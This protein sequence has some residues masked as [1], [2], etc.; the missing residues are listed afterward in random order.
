[1]PKRSVV[2]FVNGRQV[3]VSATAGTTL[4]RFLRDEL[5]LTGTK[6]GC[7]QGQCGACTVLVDGRPEKSCLLKLSEVAGCQVETIE[8]LAG[9]GVLHPLQQAFIQCGAV[10]CGFCTPGMILAA[11]GLL[12]EK[13]D[14]SEEEIKEALSQNLC[15]C[16]GYISVLEAVRHAARVLKEGESVFTPRLPG[17]GR[18]ILGAS[19]PDKDGQNRVTGKLKFAGDIFLDR[20]L[21]GKLLLSPF[22]HAEIISI[23]TAEAKAMPGVKAVLTAEDVPGPNL[24]GLIQP[25]QPV[26]A[27]EKVRFVGDVVAAVFA[28]T[29][30]QAEKAVRAVQLR[31]Q[32]LEV[33]SSPE[34]ALKPD[35]PLIHSGGNLLK[36]ANI[37][38]GD[39]VA[40]FAQA[41]IT[42]EEDFATLPVEHAYLE[43]EAGVAAPQ[44]GGGVTVWFGTQ[45]PFASRDQIASNLNLPKEKV[46]VIGTPL[47]GGF[48]GKCDVTIE[49]ILALGALVTGQPVKISLSR[50]ES[51]RISVKRHAFYTHY[52]IGAK[53]D[54][55]FTALEA[56]LVSD[57]GAYAGLSAGVLEQ[58]MIFSG[59]PYHWPN[60]SIEGY[61]VYT[62]NIPGGAF[63]G[64]GINQVHFALESMLDMLARQLNLDPFDLRL[65]N[66]LEVGSYTVTGE[67]LKASVAIKETLTQAR[68]ALQAITPT[69]VGKRIG[70]GVAAGYKNV[71]SGRGNVNFAGAKLSLKADGR[72]LLAASAVD[73]G[74][75]VS[76]VLSQIV[77]AETGIDYSLIDVIT[78]DTAT[79][80][81]G[82]GAIGQ[83]QTYVCGN[84][85]LAASRRFNKALLSYVSQHLDL[86]EDDLAIQGQRVAQKGTGKAVIDL[87][88]LARLAISE[89]EELAGEYEYFAPQTF[90]LRGDKEASFPVFKDGRAALMFDSVAAS[91]YDPS[92]GARL[93][94][95]E[96]ILTEFDP[97]V[98][99]NYFAYDYTTQVAIVEVDQE[100]GQCRLLHLISVHD[101]GKVINFQKIKG[102]LEGSGVMG[103]G[104]ALSE[105]FIMKN[106]INITKSLKQCGIPTIK[107]IPRIDVILVEDPDPGGPYGAKGVSEVAL[108]PTAPAITNAIYD[109]VGVRITSL[110]ATKEKILA[111]L[112][113]RGVK[114]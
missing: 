50:Q 7:S 101:A 29:R 80:P 92:S 111:G 114:E 86:K 12:N 22:P 109:A 49:I 27:R 18:D 4:L 23:D 47:G 52:K 45:M 113:R 14:P 83:R 15:R 91:R 11:K 32:P 19:L 6:D 55:Q 20:M 10:Q 88:L 43:T 57:A 61:T 74:Q 26:L 78:G 90:P 21:Y 35:A 1:M 48:G 79:V 87:N 72:A 96:Q 100:S 112:K 24:F 17:F 8:G 66:A 28:E 75:G 3:S 93:T 2:F 76:T 82:A 37:N 51:L 9:D 73:M 59:G 70:V 53:K 69:K 102:Q 95:G 42:L 46:R 62:N 108:V 58:A 38:R 94:E 54:G 67:R 98:Y 30:K 60:V 68:K 25:D 64:F 5:H 34:E 33:V 31:Y 103:M 110:P 84:A 39:I 65:K 81:R 106:G 63:R 40:G 77:A 99:R 16:T 97:D 71:G 85:V 89:G 107:D 13:P 41:D 104:Y 105:K 36:K 56:R 44:S